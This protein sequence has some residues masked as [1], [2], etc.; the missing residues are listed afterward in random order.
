MLRMGSCVR[1]C[2]QHFIPSH[3]ERQG[4]LLLS[5]L[6]FR[7]LRMIPL[8]NHKLTFDERIGCI[9]RHDD[10]VPR[11]HR[12]VFTASLS[13]PQRLQRLRLSPWSWSDRKRVSLSD[14]SLHGPFELVFMTVSAK[15]FALFSQ[16]DIGQFR[17]ELD[18][19]H[20]LCIPGDKIRWKLQLVGFSYDKKSANVVMWKDKEYE[21]VSSA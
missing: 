4:F 19:Y 16:Q 15:G 18:L 3:K 12:A 6:D 2:R 20:K 8:A 9:T 21:Y 7:C 17:K 14:S 10:F 5:V 11:S 1:F 13:F